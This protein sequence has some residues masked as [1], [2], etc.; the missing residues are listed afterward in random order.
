MKK[1][2]PCIF[3]KIFYEQNKDL[4]RNIITGLITSINIM[5]E[6]VTRT[7]GISVIKKGKEIAI[8]YPG[9]YIIGVSF[10]KE[11]LM[12]LRRLLQRFVIKIEKIYG[13]ILSESQ[14]TESFFTPIEK[15]CNEFF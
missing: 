1:T 12:S 6:K 2:G 10:C 14:G 11:D 15:I 7:K 9:N 3:S 8:I 4:D 13:K 5:L